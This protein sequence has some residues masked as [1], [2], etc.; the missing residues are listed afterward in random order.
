[1]S[2]AETESIIF[3]WSFVLIQ[4][5]TP[6]SFQHHISTLAAF[7]IPRFQL[8]LWYS[9]LEDSFHLETFITEIRTHLPSW[10]TIHSS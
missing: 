10:H 1:M 4:D 3:Q 8:V 6:S 9:L 5:Y 2:N 7:F